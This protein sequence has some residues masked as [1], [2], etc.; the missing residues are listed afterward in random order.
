MN[1]KKDNKIINEMISTEKSYNESLTRLEKVLNNQPSTDPLLSDLK[2]QIA[3]L[4][5]ISDQLISNVE[6]SLNSELTIEDQAKLT[7]QRTQLLK[8]FYAAYKPYAQIYHRYLNDVKNKPAAFEKL[9]TAL[10][11]DSNKLRFADHLIVPIQRG[12]RYALLVNS[13]LKSDGELDAGLKAELVKIEGL[14]KENLDT[15]NSALTIP[16]V[17]AAGYKVGDISRALYARFFSGESAAPV[18]PAA[19]NKPYQFGDYTR[20]LVERLM[21]A[22]EVDQEPEVNIEFK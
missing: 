18:P 11:N 4:K 12:P 21:A 7:L 8:A 22:D 3:V 16:N 15:I 17:P 19:D 13:L 6:R 2:P 1:E 20:A 9:D 14:I 10:M 5:G